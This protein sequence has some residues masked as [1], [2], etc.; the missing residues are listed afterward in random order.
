MSLL[1]SFSKSFLTIGKAK[2]EIITEKKNVIITDKEIIV[3]G[4]KFEIPG[5]EQSIEVQT[6]DDELIE[7]RGPS[8][9]IKWIS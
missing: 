6:E 7:V 8:I 5:Y 4:V 3:D 1:N 9:N 2:A